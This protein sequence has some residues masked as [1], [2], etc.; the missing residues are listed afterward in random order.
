SCRNAAAT[1][2]RSSGYV[3][4][5]QRARV[6]SSR[7]RASRR[8][9]ASRIACEIRNSPC[10]AAA[11]RR[12]SAKP[13]RS[14]ANTAGVK[15]H[16]FIEKSKY[17]ASHRSGPA[18]KFSDAAPQKG[19]HRGGEAPHVHRNERVPRQSHRPA[20]SIGSLVR[21]VRQAPDVHDLLHGFEPP[22]AVGTTHRAV[23]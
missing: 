16:R 13:P 18:N 20:V 11:P 17:H 7:T 9:T 1:R 22:V 15:A 10:P 12:N 19:E 14:R 2:G 8:R 23:H 4:P 6:P 21:A 3:T 5:S